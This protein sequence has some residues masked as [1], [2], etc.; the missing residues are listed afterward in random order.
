METIETSCALVL[1]A[2]P[3]IQATW[4]TRM[5]IIPKLLVSYV[6]G[7]FQASQLEG[8]RCLRITISS[9]F[10]LRIFRSLK[11][12]Y[13]GNNPQFKRWQ[14]PCLIVRRSVPSCGCLGDWWRIGRPDAVSSRSVAIRS[15]IADH[16]CSERESNLF[17][18]FDTYLHLVRSDTT[19][20][21]Q[22]RHP[23]RHRIWN[24]D[25]NKITQRFIYILYRYISDGV[26]IKQ[27]LRCN[28]IREWLF[29]IGP[30]SAIYSI[31][32]C[33]KDNILS[34]TICIVKYRDALSVEKCGF[35][36]FTWY[37]LRVFRIIYANI[38]LKNVK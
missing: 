5:P 26:A 7:R 33:A 22:A 6:K 12:D 36:P 17:C 35:W 21:V 4:P 2:C 25:K 37:K 13:L 3:R 8:V 29:I 16:M 20:R 32:L 19:Q 27:I 9:V 10:L 1:W 11:P 30:V 28:A 31:N 24:D 23:T 14:M 34:D 15:P 18:S 38:P